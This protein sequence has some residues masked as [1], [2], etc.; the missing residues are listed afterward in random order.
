[1]RYEEGSGESD[2][3]LTLVGW[4]GARSLRAYIPLH[5]SVHHL[6]ILGEDCSKFEKN[7]FQENRNALASKVEEQDEQ[8][9][10]DAEGMQVDEGILMDAE[11]APCTEQ[12]DS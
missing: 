5:E 1:M 7:K 3:K 6:R 11:D 10:Q 12:G 4:K 8:K 9:V 2:L